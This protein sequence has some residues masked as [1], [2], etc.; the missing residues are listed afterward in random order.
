VEPVGA[1]AQ[2]EKV[3]RPLSAGVNEYQT[4]RETLGWH[5]GAVGSPNV[6]APLMSEVREVR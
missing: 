1:S 5:E 6:V 2:D 4:L 3:Y